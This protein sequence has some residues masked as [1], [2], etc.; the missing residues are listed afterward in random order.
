MAAKPGRWFYDNHFSPDNRWMWIEVPELAGCCWSPD[1]T[2]LYC[3]SDREGHGCIC[4]QRLDTATKRSKGVPLA[5]FHSHS[6]RRSQGGLVVG[7]GRIVFEISERTA[8]IWMAEW[9]EH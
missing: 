7:R 8:N 9:K 1:G 2:F 6:S 3:N 4:A 5:I